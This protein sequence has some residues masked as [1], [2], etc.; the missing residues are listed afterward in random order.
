MNISKKARLRRSGWVVGDAVEFLDLTPQEALFIELKLALAAGVRQR[1]EQLGFTQAALAEQLGS[2]QSRIAKMEAA[3][4]SVTVDLIV[5]SL[6]AIGTTP[7]EIAK[8]IKR[9]GTDRRAA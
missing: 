1:R 9:T 2:S 3:D 6:L 5:R 8:L 4:R 7:G